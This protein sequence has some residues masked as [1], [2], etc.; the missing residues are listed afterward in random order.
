MSKIGLIHLCRIL[1]M[2]ES[3]HPPE[4]TPYLLDASADEKLAEGPQQ[5]IKFVWVWKAF[6]DVRI[7]SAGTNNP[8]S[9]SRIVPDLSPPRPGSGV[10]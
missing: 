10:M 5:L 8:K 6:D 1:E 4:S 2:L 7:S 3:G 9:T